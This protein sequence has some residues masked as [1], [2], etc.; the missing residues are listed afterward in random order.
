MNLFDTVP[1]TYLDR[2]CPRCG[3]YEPVKFR[4]GN[5]HASLATAEQWEWAYRWA[6]E[7]MGLIRVA[8]RRVRPEIA[9]VLSDAELL[10]ETIAGIVRGLLGWSQSG[11]TKLTTYLANSVGF[12]AR[13]AKLSEI[14]TIDP[15][16]LKKVAG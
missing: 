11:G 5:C 10:S 16:R 8:F 6:A 14:E 15:E 4:C 7:N 2:N 9:A 12:S 1:P 3:R 13:K